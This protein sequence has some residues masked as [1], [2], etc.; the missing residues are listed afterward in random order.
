MSKVAVGFV[1]AIAMK[2]WGEWSWTRDAYNVGVSVR[3]A[4]VRMR[5]HRRELGRIMCRVCEMKAFHA[6]ES[7]E[8]RL[9]VGKKRV[10]KVGRGEG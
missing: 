3:G 7:D 5:W 9:D 8:I 10:R 2:W 1:L 6:M 4:I